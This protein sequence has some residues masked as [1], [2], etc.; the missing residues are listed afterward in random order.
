MSIPIANPIVGTNDFF[1]ESDPVVDIG[2]LY[3]TESPLIGISHLD[4]LCSL[5]GS[6]AD[7]KYGRL[8]GCSSSFWQGQEWPQARQVPNKNQVRK[9]LDP[10]RRGF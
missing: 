8:L 7:S 4:Q 6:S 1:S 5:H 3:K 9:P 2:G 10:R